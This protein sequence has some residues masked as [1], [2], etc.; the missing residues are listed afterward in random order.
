MTSEEKSILFLCLVPRLDKGQCKHYLSQ[1]GLNDD[2]LSLFEQKRP[3][4]L[5]NDTNKRILEEFQ[6]KYWITK[7]EVDDRDSNYYRAYGRRLLTGAE[8]DDVMV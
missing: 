8:K 5:L 3:K 2:F 4:I 7:F 1:L 6:S